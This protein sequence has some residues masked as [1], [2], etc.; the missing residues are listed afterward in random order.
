[1]NG[2]KEN[3]QQKKKSYKIEYRETERYRDKHNKTK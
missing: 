2:K 1:M 3:Q